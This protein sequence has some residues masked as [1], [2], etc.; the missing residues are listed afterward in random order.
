MPE[1][2]SQPAT[3]KQCESC[4]AVIGTSETKCPKCGVDFEE[5]A[6]TIATVEKASA[7]LEKRRAKAAPPKEEPKTETKKTSKLRSLG[8]ILRKSS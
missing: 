5:L 6:D 1:P 2:E 8:S 7:I 4:D 3:T